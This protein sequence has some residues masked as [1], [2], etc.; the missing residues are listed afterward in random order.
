M[1]V[2]HL[3]CCSMRP[4]NERFIH[5]S[6]SWIA[7]GRM[8]AHCLLIE[9][10]DGLVLIDSGVGL[11]DV[12]DPARRLGGMFMRATNP[13]LDPAET[14]VRQIEAL[15][16]RRNDVRHVVLTHLDVDHAGGIADFPSA[17]VH[18]YRDEHHAAMNPRGFFETHR[19]RQCQWAHGPDW[20]LHDVDGE[21]FMGLDAVRAIVEPE[22]LLVPSSGHSRGHACVAVN[23]DDGW[24]LHCGDAYFN[25][26]ELDLQHPWC[27]AGLAL[28]QRTVAFDDRKRIAN[29]ARLR[30]I[31][32][33]HASD[34]RIFSAHDPDELA[35]F[36]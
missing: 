19:Y 20:Q 8:V 10:N 14:A 26:N 29:Q 1:K 28:F 25:H 27:P 18:V 13:R 31:S 11:D 35:A 3:N 16:F 12:A 7:K 15:G 36:G 30:D 22:V 9:T 32:R 2:H 5:G 4:Y 23:T 24:L 33:S 17:K 34:V 6:G 21:R